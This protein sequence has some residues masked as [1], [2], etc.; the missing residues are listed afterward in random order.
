MSIRPS[1]L[2]N[3]DAPIIITIFGIISVGYM[4]DKTFI[5]IL[6]D[7]HYDEEVEIDEI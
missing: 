7:F 4:R 3:R 2:N 1:K 5:Q 6:E